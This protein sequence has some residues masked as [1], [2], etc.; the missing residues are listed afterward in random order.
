MTKR[1]AGRVPTEQP[2]PRPSTQYRPPKIAKV[3]IPPATP[4]VTYRYDPAGRFLGAYETIDNTTREYD[5]GGQVVHTFVRDGR[6]VV[7]F[8]G[9]GKVIEHKGGAR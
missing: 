3:A 2:P 9:D 5:A 7:V 4:G 1:G 6:R 8:D